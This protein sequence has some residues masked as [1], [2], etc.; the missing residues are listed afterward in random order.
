MTT[1]TVWAEIPAML[2]ATP[3]D[4]LERM[5]AAC[6]AHYRKYERGPEQERLDAQKMF[7]MI[8]AEQRRR[9]LAPTVIK[10]MLQ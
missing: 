7:D 6:R 2:A 5:K 8:K 4:A 3:D 10:G 1:M 9:L